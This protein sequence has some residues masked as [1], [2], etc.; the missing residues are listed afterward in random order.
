MRSRLASAKTQ[1]AGHDGVAVVSIYQKTGA[2]QYGCDCLGPISDGECSRCGESR[3]YPREGCHYVPFHFWPLG[4]AYRAAWTGQSLGFNDRLPAPLRAIWWLLLEHDAGLRPVALPE[5]HL[6]S[7]VSD[8][9]RRAA[10]FF[11]VK[12]RLEVSEGYDRPIP[13]PVRL[14]AERLRVSRDDAHRAIKA[15][16]DH[17]T[18]IVTGRADRTYLYR[19]VP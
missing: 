10:E 1:P 6:A 15:L 16:R 9:E 12:C 8:T 18:I 5:L 17:G 11:A 4:D 3:S 7:D 14:V 13:F 19:P 2:L